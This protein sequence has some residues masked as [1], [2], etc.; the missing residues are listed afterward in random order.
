MPKLLSGFIRKQIAKHLGKQVLDA[1]LTRPTPGTRTA[2]AV[3]AG[4]NPTSVSYAAKGFVSDYD[5]S[6]FD[7]TVIVRGDRQIVLL[8]GTIEGGIVPTVNDRVTIADFAGQTP[9]EY[10]VVG[11][12]GSDPDGATFT[13]QARR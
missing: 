7:G 13:L 4:T 6:D 12:V 3:S 2:G 1:T 11:P 9:V 10:K 8:G 5:E